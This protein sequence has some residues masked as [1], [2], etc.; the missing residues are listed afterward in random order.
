MNLQD[1]PRVKE[2]LIEYLKVDEVPDSIKDPSQLHQLK[3]AFRMDCS[4]Q[5]MINICNQT[6]GHDELAV[7]LADVVLNTNAN[8]AMPGGLLLV[9]LIEIEIVSYIDLML[10]DMEA[11]LREIER[12]NNQEDRIDE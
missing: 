10:P 3:R 12:S 6:L 9:E 4:P 1:F 11:V 5:L 2:L 8:P 7:N